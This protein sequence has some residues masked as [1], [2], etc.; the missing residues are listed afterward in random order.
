MAASASAPAQDNSFD[1]PGTYTADELKRKREVLKNALLD[2]YQQYSFHGNFSGSEKI[3]QWL[4]VANSAWKVDKLFLKLTKNLIAL[5]IADFYFSVYEISRAFIID[6][7][8][9]IPGDLSKNES[10]EITRGRMAAHF[11][12]TINNINPIL[13]KSYFDYI[14]ETFVRGALTLYTSSWDKSK[15]TN[16]VLKMYLLDYMTLL[17]RTSYTTKYKFDGRNAVDMKTATLSS[18]EYVEAINAF[19]IAITKNEESLV[20]EKLATVQALYKAI[21]ETYIAPDERSIWIEQAT[22]ISKGSVLVQT[23]DLLYFSSFLCETLIF[24]KDVPLTRYDDIARKLTTVLNA[25]DVSPET[26]NFINQAAQ[27]GTFT[28]SMQQ[29]KAISLLVNDVTLTLNRTKGQHAELKREYD[30]LLRKNAQTQKMLT[31]KENSITFYQ[32]MGLI[33]VDRIQSI[34]QTQWEIIDLDTFI[35]AWNE[36]ANGTKQNAKVGLFVVLLEIYAAAFPSSRK[37]IREKY[38]QQVVDFFNSPESESVLTSRL[39][40]LIS[41]L[42]IDTT[43]DNDASPERIA[44][45]TNAMRAIANNN[46]FQRK[47]I[48]MAIRNVLLKVWRVTQQTINAETLMAILQQSVSSQDNFIVRQLGIDWQDAFTDNAVNVSKL[49]DILKQALVLLARNKQEFDQLNESYVRATAAVDALTTQLK[50]IE[51]NL[52]IL[53]KEETGS[54]DEELRFRQALEEQNKSRAQIRQQIVQL[55]GSLVTSKNESAM[56][57]IEQNIRNLKARDQEYLVKIQNILKETEE[58]GRKQAQLREKILMSRGEVSVVKGQR[59]TAVNELRDITN[60]INTLLPNV[61][62]PIRPVGDDEY[63]INPEWI[64]QVISEIEQTITGLPQLRDTKSTQ[65]ARLLELSAQ[66]RQITEAFAAKEEELRVIQRQHRGLQEDYKQITEAMDNFQQKYMTSFQTQSSGAQRYIDM[67]NNIVTRVG[68][69]ESTNFALRKKITGLETSL[70]QK[71]QELSQLN[72]TMMTASSTGSGYDDRYTKLTNS[73]SKLTR[74]KQQLEE[75]KTML[76]SQ[77]DAQ[78]GRYSDLFHQKSSVDDELTQLKSAKTRNL[79][80]IQELNTQISELEA[81]QTNLKRQIRDGEN[82][83]AESTRA[84]GDAKAE[85]QRLKGEQSRHIT[86]A[87]ELDQQRAAT[88]KLQASFAELQRKFT[89]ASSSSTSDMSALQSN[90][91]RVRSELDTANRKVADLEARL[92][93]ATREKDEKERKLMELQRL[94]QDLSENV[95]K[96]SDT[97]ADKKR[98]Q[99]TIQGQL[100]VSTRQL[101]QVKG[102]LKTAQTRNEELEREVF[103]LKLR[104]AE[105]EG[106]IALMQKQSTGHTVDIARV[107][108]AMVA[109]KHEIETLRTEKEKLER[110][111]SE[112][113]ASNKIRESDFK[114]V[115][116]L[117]R[118]V[119]QKASTLQ[120]DPQQVI[121]LL[122]DFVLKLDSVQPMKELKAIENSIIQSATSVD[123][124][125]IVTE[126]R[127]TEE[128]IQDIQRAAVAISQTKI[129]DVPKI[130]PLMPLPENEQQRVVVMATDDIPTLTRQTPVP[131]IQIV[132]EFTPETHND[133]IE[134][135]DIEDAHEQFRRIADYIE[136]QDVVLKSKMDMFY[137]FVEKVGG[138]AGVATSFW[139]KGEHKGMRGLI[140]HVVEAST[141]VPQTLFHI[142]DIKN[143]SAFFRLVGNAISNEIHRNPINYSNELSLGG[144]YKNIMNALNALSS[145][146]R[147]YLTDFNYNVKYTARDEADLK[148]KMFKDLT[149]SLHIE[150]EGQTVERV[151]KLAVSKYINELFNKKQINEIEERMRA[152]SSTETHGTMPFTIIQSL[153]NPTFYSAF[154]YVFNY[155]GVPLDFDDANFNAAVRDINLARAVSTIYTHNIITSRVGL[156]TIR[157]KESSIQVSVVLQNLTGYRIQPQELASTSKRERQESSSSYFEEPDTKLQRLSYI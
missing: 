85:I 81:T 84:L 68:N 125:I 41:E 115:E 66:L 60:Q 155:I 31:Q 19:V 100:V 133:V 72:A 62:A 105:L 157:V 24:N 58:L 55:E 32:N 43:H 71:A 87:I 144:P 44:H 99:E 91:D 14:R 148:Q 27:N 153:V 142:G 13:E 108:Q 57:Q 147:F 1:L 135:I 149:D 119:V 67:I 21:V 120:I 129:P 33:L 29:M 116:E 65:E 113:T 107:Q 86:L 114:M 101:A 122:S 128:R 94:E 63:Q 5:I 15:E 156:P 77:L 137:S 20:K 83:L 7:S 47:A 150:Q 89:Q 97:L 8:R 134:L 146:T 17:D 131:P 38:Y 90:L 143:K 118:I 34:S 130:T 23:R 59:K 50:N 139:K 39:Q 25:T 88:K 106:S 2:L 12:N 82:S 145:K 70:G 132:N 16:D 111:V 46:K 10:S 61:K 37:I 93:T 56:R 42:E 140:A 54:S 64:K 45:V 126:A 52:D 40:T 28:S 74:E 53:S 51:Y 109:E 117:N 123:D 35:K 78:R 103:A 141:R 121:N 73:L 136:G 124:D 151:S 92:R 30:E 98:S 138:F 104:Q 127:S 26:R 110:L 6:L 112:L 18:R 9:K 11:K 80:R 96:L 48:P 69:M 152:R 95:A 36:M 49:V 154:E 75:V 4:K 3:K 22:T 79:A 76:E 102:E